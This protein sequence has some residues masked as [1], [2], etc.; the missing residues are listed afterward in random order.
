MVDNCSLKNHLLK[1]I[2][3]PNLLVSLRIRGCN[4]CD[5]KKKIKNQKP[6]F[7][8]IFKIQFRLFFRIKV[9]PN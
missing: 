3:E 7:N 8:I 6:Q 1:Y 4:N 2:I 5:R 9:T